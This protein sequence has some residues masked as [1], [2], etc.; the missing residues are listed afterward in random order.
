MAFAELSG[1]RIHHRL[2][3]PEAA[4]VLVLSNSLGTDLGLWEPQLGALARRFR[5]LRYDA[6]GHGASS[7]PP[8]PWTVPD[9]GRDVLGL[10]DALGIAAVAVCGLSLGGM[11]GMWLAAN[12]PARVRALVLASTAARLGPP[13]VWDARIAAARERGMAALTETVLARWFTPAFRAARADEV[14]RVR[15]MLLATPAEGYAAACAA[16]R[17]MDQREAVAGIGAPTLVI[18]GTHDVAT[19]PADGRFLAERIRGARLVELD[20]AHLSNVEAAEPFTAAV[21]AFLAGPS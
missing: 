19:P 18:S 11:T 3:G 17:D 12:A 14:D 15:R 2:D 6:R 1:V 21:L 20:A 7:V 10:L 13:E 16:I 9:L 5:V 8:G 4:P